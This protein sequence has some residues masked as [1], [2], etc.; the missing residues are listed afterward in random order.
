MAARA[1]SIRMATDVPP[2][3]RLR[4]RFNI[5][6]PTV[7]NALSE[8][9]GTALL[10]FI[11]L[12]I[13]MQFILSGEKLNTWINVNIGWGLAITFCVYACCKTSGG[14]FN[15][16]VSLAMVTLGH[17]SVKDFFAYCVAQ[18][19]GAFVG[20]LGAY[21]LYYDQFT[22]FAGA[23]RTILGAKATAGCFCSFP[24][25]HVSNATAF[26]DQVA[27]T[28]LLVLFVCVIIDKRNGIP[29]SAH[30]MLFGLV[31]V[32]IGTAF[33]MNLGYPINPARDLGP[34]I[35]AA[36][37]YGSGVF[38]YHGY[39]FWIPVIAPLFGGVL[40][41][42]LYHFFVGAHISDVVVVEPTNTTY[43]LAD[44]AKQ[45]LKAGSEA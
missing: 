12:G 23:Y 9:F 25:L 33:G 19:T 40:G 38:S 11:G 3:E 4:A 31:V 26:F 29:T 32:M 43:L 21:F 8:F 2:T 22:K 41:A 10:L 39:Y 30:P 24:A 35:L 6:N 16:A 34:R 20:S 17:L 27:G 1:T 37:I 15:P 42:W 36:F 45:P 5:K 44:E 28:G 18:V 14:H 7:R 13:V